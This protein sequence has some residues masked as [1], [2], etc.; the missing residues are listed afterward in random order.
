MKEIQ[1]SVKEA[2]RLGMMREID[3]K[4]LTLARASQELGISLRQTKRIRKRYLE[5]GDKGVISLKRGKPSNRKIPQA[6]RDRA[7]GIV[8]TKYPDFGPTFA[9]E[10]LIEHEIKVSH[11]TLRKWLIEK[12]IWKCKRSKQ[13]R[14]YQRR[15]RRESSGEL[16][17]IDGS[18]HDWFEGRCAKCCLIM[19]VDDATSKVTGAR[20]VPVENAEAYKS[21]LK[22]HLLKYG[23]PR[24]IYSDRHSIFR[25][26]R[27]EQGGR[28][29]THFGGILRELDIELICARSPQAKGRVERKNGLFQDRLVKEMRLKGIKSLQEGNDYLPEFIEEMNKR[30]AISP[31]SSVDAHRK[32][33]SQIDLGRVFA[34]KET[35]KLTKNLIL[36]YKNEQY[37]IQT[38]TP[39]RMRHTR[40]DIIEREGKVTIEYQG[41][42]LEYKKWSEIPYEKPKILD[43]K[44]IAMYRYTK[45][46]HKPGKHHPWR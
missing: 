3:K 42:Q 15:Q 2:E 16:I 9:S 10:K 30:F 19:F 32:L 23:R 37:M 8:R 25:M 33:S 27:E 21:V 4:R 7:I 31:T 35:R 36:Q 11:E 14:S 29:E 24:A 41:E 34:I 38:Q 45:K 43:S 5:L 39:N 12:G 18:P 28:G 22:E 6:V 44:E 13:K 1:M 17:Q 26:N 40:V 46:V 20:F